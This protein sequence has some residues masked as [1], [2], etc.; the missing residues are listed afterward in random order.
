MIQEANNFD[1]II[2]GGSYAGLSAAMALGRSLRTVLVIDN[3]LPCN[4]QT[5]YS[6]NFLTQD[7]ESPFSIR[8]LAA[9]QVA[10]YDTVQFING[11]ASAAT[12][13]GDSFLVKTKEGRDFDY[14]NNGV[15]I[16]ICDHKVIE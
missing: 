14:D 10:K 7:G 5:P 8:Q 12:A 1:V 4:R 15:S 13:K 6:H 2:I 16:K 3:N 11:T 9:E